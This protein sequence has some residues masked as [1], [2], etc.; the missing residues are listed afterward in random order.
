MVV[1]YLTNYDSICTY[2]EIHGIVGLET[3]F[4]FDNKCYEHYGDVHSNF[5]RKNK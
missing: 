1:K 4:M 5:H 3:V 2:F